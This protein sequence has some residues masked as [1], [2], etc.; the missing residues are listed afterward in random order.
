MTNIV[1]S[2]CKFI[3]DSGENF[4]YPPALFFFAHDRGKSPPRLHKARIEDR[5][6]N[7]RSDPKPQV[8]R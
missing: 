2:Q 3:K 7:A 4:N 6:I 8:C 5:G 1:S